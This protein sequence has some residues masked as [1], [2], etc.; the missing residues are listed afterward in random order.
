[1]VQGGYFDQKE[2]YV[3]VGGGV[4]VYVFSNVNDEEEERKSI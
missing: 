4:G 1:M 3:Y 2:W